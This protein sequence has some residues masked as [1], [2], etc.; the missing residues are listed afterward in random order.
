MSNGATEALERREPTAVVSGS[1]SESSVVS[2]SS[3]DEVV[4]HDEGEVTLIAAA[5]VR[6]AMPPRDFGENFVGA[7]VVDQLG[8]VLGIMH[9]PHDLEVLEST[10]R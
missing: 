6:L 2:N 7:V 9:S 10:P 4:T 3:A 8:N 1:G 5:D